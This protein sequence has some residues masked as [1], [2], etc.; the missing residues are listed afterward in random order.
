MAIEVLL[1][2]NDLTLAKNLSA[3]SK[4]CIDHISVHPC[5]TLV[6]FRELKQKIEFEF[7]IFDESFHSP[8][9][10]IIL[11]AEKHRNREGKGA[12]SLLISSTIENGKVYEMLEAGYTDVIL[13]PVDLSILLH[14]VDMYRPNKKTL[15]EDLLF[16]MEVDG[17]VGLMLNAKVVQA[18][19][20]GAILRSD[21]I[22]AK[23]E[24]VSINPRMFDA[25]GHYEGEDCLAR[26]IASSPS[27]VA[28]KFDSQVTFV[29][30]SPKFMTA[31][32][33]WMR[34]QYVVSTSSKAR[35]K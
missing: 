35:G 24:I 29:A 26:V 9:L 14:K 4:H 31:M 33:L 23:N 13:K 25:D 5:T 27:R 8:E 12:A 32:R 10:E 22:L 19:E 34:G 3:A 1:L 21:M 7:L 18:S 20:F 6:R 28:K 16:R 15:K 17:D 11:T 30:P 2:S